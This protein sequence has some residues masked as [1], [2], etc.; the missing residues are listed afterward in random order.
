MEH[1]NTRKVSIGIF[2]G[3]C[4]FLLSACRQNEMYFEFRSLANAE[5]DKREV[6]RFE[7]PV[8][9][10]ASTYDVLLEVRNNNDYPFRNLWLFVDYQT[11][12]GKVRSDTIDVELA[13][14]Y[15]KWYGKG[16]HLYTY[17]FPYEWNV[18]YPDTG[19]YIYAVRHGMRVNPLKGI[20]DIG[21]RISKKVDE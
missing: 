18:Q 13:D 7:V 15:G 17:T 2:A 8:N 4:F 12:D 20:S 3:I 5:W 9:E 1:R 10:T 14:A 21:L 19:I 6:L 16:I 11:P